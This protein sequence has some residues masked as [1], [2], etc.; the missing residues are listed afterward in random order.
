MVSRV[1]FGVI[2]GVV[3]LLYLW[4]AYQAVLP[5]ISS[6]DWVAY[7]GAVLF[8]ATGVGAALA[9]INLLRPKRR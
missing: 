8:L 3:G 9:G 6:G 4:V 1:L 7:V 2:L 5:G